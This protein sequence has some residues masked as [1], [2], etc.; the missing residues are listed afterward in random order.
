MDEHELSQYTADAREESTGLIRTTYQ[1]SPKFI[2]PRHNGET[3]TDAEGDSR[4]CLA[5][6][7]FGGGAEAKAILSKSR[8]R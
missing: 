7:D 1:A 6:K 5:N 8:W 2:P 3:L 4:R